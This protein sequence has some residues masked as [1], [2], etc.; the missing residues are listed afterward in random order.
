MGLLRQIKNNNKSVVRQILDLFPRWIL[1]NCTK[2]YQ[3][4]KVCSKYKTYDQFVALTYG[5][6]YICHTISDISTGVGVSGTFIS[7]LV[8]KQNPARPNMSDGN[9]KLD[10]QV[11]DNLYYKLLSHYKS[12]LKKHHQSHIIEEIKGQSI[13]FIDSSTIPLCLSMFD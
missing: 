7:D 10:W 2:A 8:L 3:T 11:F 12:V 1:D 4:D 5:Q 9:R 13:K 6:L